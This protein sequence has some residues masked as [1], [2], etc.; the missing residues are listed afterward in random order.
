MSTAVDIQEKENSHFGRVEDSK[1]G[2]NASKYFE[3][4]DL[5]DIQEIVLQ[6]TDQMKEF[7]RAGKYIE[8]QSA[9]IKI[10]EFKKEANRK[11]KEQ[12]R[13]RH[14]KERKEIEESHLEEFNKFNEFW[15]KKM[16]DFQEEAAKAENELLSRHQEELTK[17]A[18]ELEKSLPDRPK[19]SSE[20]LNLRR[21]EES[22][23]RQREYIEAHKVQQKCNS[24]VMEEIEKWNTIRDQK[25]RNQISQLV[26]KQSQELNAFRQRVTSNQ[27]ESNKMRTAELERLIQKYQNIRKEVENQHQMEMIKVEKSIK[28]NGSVMR[29]TFSSR[30]GPRTNTSIMNQSRFGKNERSPTTKE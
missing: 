2:A 26:T 13:S 19:D 11:Y 5:E 18:E 16:L 30:M 10:E 12:L 15:D 27:D 6:L 9:L 14:A 25:I 29:S 4:L 3:K 22:L 20:I 1:L 21:I 17:F 8:A 23:A 28:T 24:I 7:E